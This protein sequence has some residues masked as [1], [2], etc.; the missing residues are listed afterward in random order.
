MNLERNRQV[1]GMCREPQGIKAMCSGC[2]R[3]REKN[4]EAWSATPDV[5]PQIH[6]ARDG[7]KRCRQWITIP[8]TDRKGIA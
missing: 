7:T 5:E 8:W 1:E 6:E 4:P 2:K 3:N